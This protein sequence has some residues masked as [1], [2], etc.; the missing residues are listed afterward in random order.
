[1]IVIVNSEIMN[2]VEFSGKIEK[3]KIKVPKEYQNIDKS[4]RVIMLFEDADN[5]VSKKENLR[6]TLIKMKNE[7]MFSSI[8]NPVLWQKKI[9]DDWE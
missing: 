6:N 5:V 3:G 4:V 9:R 7:E 8:D 2:A 1:M